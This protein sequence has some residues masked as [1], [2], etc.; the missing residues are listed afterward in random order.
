MKLKKLKTLTVD[1][2][3]LTFEAYKVAFPNKTEK[4]YY[5]FVEK[6][7]KKDEQHIQSSGG[8]AKKP[9]VSRRNST[10][11]RKEKPSGAN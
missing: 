11:K 7:Q 1:I 9:T 2:D 8:Q 5:E 4:E 6:K 10:K 3:K